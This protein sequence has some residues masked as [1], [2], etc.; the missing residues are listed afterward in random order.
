MEA[1]QYLFLIQGNEKGSFSLSG[2]KNFSSSGENGDLTATITTFTHPRTGSPAQYMLVEKDLLE[3]QVARPRNHEKASFFIDQAVQAEGA[4]YFASRVD[5]LFLLLPILKKHT[6]KWCPLDQVLAEAGCAGLR[7]LQHLDASKLCDVND[8]LGPETILYRLNED[9]VLSWLEEKVVRAAR[10]FQEVADAA[11]LAS[12]RAGGGGAGFAAGFT[13][14]VS[15]E[16]GRALGT[17]VGRPCTQQALEVVSEY[18]ADEWV[19]RLAERFSTERSVIFGTKAQATRK[20]KGIWEEGK[21]SDRNLELVHGTGGGEKV[22]AHLSS[23]VRMKAKPQAQT[24]GQRSLSKV[25]K[26]GMKS[27]TSFFKA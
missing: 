23:R 12:S 9:T 22:Q 15:S 27:I 8:R 4:V 6:A 20:R 3:I 5:P 10:R 18:L 14:L 21:E 24:P 26:K 1:H 19:D 25:N 17:T 11:E 7:G 2:L 13:T 16:R